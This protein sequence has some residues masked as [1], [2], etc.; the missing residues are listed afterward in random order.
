MGDDAAFCVNCGAKVEIREKRVESPESGDRLH[1]Y[2]ITNNSSI[3]EPTKF[4]AKSVNIWKPIVVLIIIATVVAVPLITL[5]SISSLRN[6][7]DTFEYNIPFTGLTNV[8]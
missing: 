7:L 6:E 2:S 4:K 5:S 3:A 8:E 1:D